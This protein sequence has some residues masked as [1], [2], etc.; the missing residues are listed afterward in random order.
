MLTVKLNFEEIIIICKQ[1]SYK[2]DVTYL[3]QL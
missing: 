2:Q 3:M 1:W